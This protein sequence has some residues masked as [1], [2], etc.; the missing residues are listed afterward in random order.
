MQLA[1]HLGKELT[2]LSTLYNPPPPPKES[3][4]WCAVRCRTPPA[5]SDCD[6]GTEPATVSARV[7]GMRRYLTYLP[8]V[9]FFHTHTR[10]GT[11]IALRKRVNCFS[12]APDATGFD[13]FVSVC[14]RVDDY[15]L[16]LN[17]QTCVWACFIRPNPDSHVFRFF[18]Y[19]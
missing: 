16:S 13:N 2:E 12:G 7:S 14:V 10:S 9:C 19:F 6:A 1:G 5:Q 15:F 3:V 8:N 11:T 4:I 18:Q 17:P